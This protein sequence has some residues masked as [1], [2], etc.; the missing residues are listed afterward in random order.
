MRRNPVLPYVL[1]CLLLVSAVSFVPVF[2]AIRISLYETRNLQEG[3]FI[4]L[5]SYAKLLADP[6]LLTNIG[7]SLIYVLCSLV[8]SISIGLLLALTLN[9]DRPFMHAFRTL[10]IAPW[11]VSQAVAAVLWLWLLNSA[12]GPI[13]Y[14]LRYLFNLETV[15]LV[16]SME[17]AM[18]VVILVNVWISY[19]L[20]TV[21]LLAALQTIPAELHEAAEIDGAGRW[22]TFRRI[23]LPLLYGTLLST[24][25]LLTL[26][27]FNMVTLI[28]VMTGG[29]PLGSTEVLSI[30][31]FREAFV[32]YQLG[33]ASAVGMV[34]FIL[35]IVF[36]TAYIRI[37]RSDRGL[38]Q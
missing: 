36:S 34:I 8:I 32:N 12:Y 13:P 22:R 20:A 19:P 23:T 7:N 11:L 4:G 17:F 6:T 35:N 18:P 29:G 25:I 37:L 38:Y 10:V 5:A 1:P 27:F 3:K 24:A 14:I 28:Y 33:Y 2:M 21:L 15:T 9:R 31:V 26:Q 16:E 30:R